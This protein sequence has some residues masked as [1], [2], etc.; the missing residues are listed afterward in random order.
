[1]RKFLTAFLFAILF[2]L[3]ACGRGRN[4]ENY[5]EA[6]YAPVFAGM[7]EVTEIPEIPAQE[8]PK[9]EPAETYAPDISAEYRSFTQAIYIH[10]DLPISEL[11][12]AA[13]AELLRGY[14]NAGY[15]VSFFLH[16]MTG[17]GIPEIFLAV[18]AP[19]YADGDCFAAVYSFG[20]GAAWRLEIGDDRDFIAFMRGAARTAIYAAPANAPGLVVVMNGAT[21]ALTGVVS[22]VFFWRYGIEQGVFGVESCG[23]IYTDLNALYEIFGTFHGVDPYVREAAISEHRHYILGDEIVT[24]EYFASVFGMRQIS[25]DD[26]APQERREIFSHRFTEKNEILTEWQ[27]E[28]VIFRTTQRVHPDMPEFAFYRTVGR[29]LGVESEYVYAGIERYTTI[30]VKDENGNVIQKIGEFMQGGHQIAL[31]I[32]EDTF[33][34]QF[35]DF[36]FDGYLDMWAHTAINHGSAGGA[37]AR[38][39]LWNPATTQFEENAQLNEIHNMTNLSVNEATQQIENSLWLGSG[40]FNTTVFEWKNGELVAAYLLAS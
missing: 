11:W 39:W 8:T 34:V 38:Y 24:G 37:W 19:E 23:K 33:G 21:A 14:E 18:A 22:T 5:P 13:Y 9:E 2:L 40:N 28:E 32:R 20:F 31:P 25:Y 4:I 27:P 7:A 29:P 10:P 26:F 6:D 36:N 17:S 15:S 16:D 12:R 3:A 1:M 35:A 30:T